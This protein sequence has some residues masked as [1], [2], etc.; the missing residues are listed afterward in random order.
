M[1]QWGPKTGK[2]HDRHRQLWQHFTKTGNFE[3]IYVSMILHSVQ[4]EGLPNVG[5]KG[6]AQNGK[7]GEEHGSLH[8]QPSYNQFYTR[9]IRKQDKNMSDVQDT[10]KD[11]FCPTHRTAHTLYK[12]PNLRQKE[13]NFY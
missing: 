11:I 13:I 1:I 12:S 5:G 2:L 10:E 3:D 9:K 4:S 8:C 7:K 6:A